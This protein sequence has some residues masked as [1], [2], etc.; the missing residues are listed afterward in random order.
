MF[1]EDLARSTRIEL[2]KHE[3]RGWLVRFGEW[4]FSP[5][6]WFL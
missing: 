3:R 6:S 5:I 4:A 1:S 2:A